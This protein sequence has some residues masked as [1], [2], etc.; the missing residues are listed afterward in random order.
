M[1]VMLIGNKSDLASKRAVS[2]EE[3]QQF[4][5]EHNLIFLETSAKTADRVEEA[6][7]STAEHIYQ[8]IVKGEFDVSNESYG[9]KIGKKG[10]V[11]AAPGNAPNSS[12]CC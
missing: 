2:V 4:A 8:K 7:L 12:G 1:T 5:Q 10:A 6:F 11:N 3:G 9:I